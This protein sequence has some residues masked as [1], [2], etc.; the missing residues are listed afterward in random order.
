MRPLDSPKKTRPRS[1]NI[2]DRFKEKFSKKSLEE[3]YREGEDENGHYPEESNKI[4][5]GVQVK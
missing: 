4:L 5:I 1:K 3:V 2:I